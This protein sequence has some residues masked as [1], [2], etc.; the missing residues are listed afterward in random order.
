[1]GVY[2]TNMLDYV[3][4]YSYQNNKRENWGKIIPVGNTFSCVANII[5]YDKNK[6]KK[7][8]MENLKKK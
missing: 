7:Y 1:M 5:F 8:M 4:F 2:F 3:L 6:K